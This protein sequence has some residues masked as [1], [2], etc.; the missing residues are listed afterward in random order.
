MTV[1]YLGVE[2]QVPVDIIDTPVKSIEVVKYDEI[3]LIE[4]LDGYWERPWAE[5]YFED[6]FKY[7]IPDIKGVV[8]KINYNDGTSKTAEVGSYVDGREITWSDNQLEKHFVLGS[9]NYITIEC[10]KLL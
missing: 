2:T 6:F 7:Y 5:H 10:N 1:S 9:D 3:K 4:N 8:V